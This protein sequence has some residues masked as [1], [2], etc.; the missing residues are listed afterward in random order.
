MAHYQLELVAEGTG[1]RCGHKQTGWTDGRVVSRLPLA[2]NCSV[3]SAELVTRLEHGGRYHAVL[4]VT[5]G[6]GLSA[7]V[8]SRSFVADL[9][10]V[11]DVTSFQF[12][13]QKSIANL[14]LHPAFEALLDPF[15]SAY[16]LNLYRLLPAPSAPNASAELGLPPPLPPGSWH[17]PSMPPLSPPMFETYVASPCNSSG[18]NASN[19]TVDEVVVIERSPAPYYDKQPLSP[20]DTISFGKS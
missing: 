5:N 3:T 11:A 6:A 15:G 13:D 17:P 16:E 9:F 4:Q 18:V 10:H 19:F 12:L 20:L 14:T 2:A 7:R 1:A 8:I